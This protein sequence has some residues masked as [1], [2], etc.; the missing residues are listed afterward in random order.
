MAPVVE[1]SVYQSVLGNHDS[2]PIWEWSIIGVNQP[3]SLAVSLNGAASISVDVTARSYR[4]SQHL[5]AGSHT[6]SVTAQFDTLFGLQASGS[7]SAVVA[8]VQSLQA[9]THTDNPDDPQYDYDPSCPGSTP[10][11]LCMHEAQRVWDALAANVVGQLEDVVVAVID[12]GYVVDMS[13]NPHDDLAGNLLTGEGYDFISSPVVAA[14]GNGID[15]DAVDKG[16][17]TKACGGAP[18]VPPSWHGT[19]VG[20][21]IAAETDNASY[22]AGMGWQWVPGV[23]ARLWVMPV[24]VLGCGGGTSYDIAQG[25]RY[26]AGLANDSETLPTTPAKVLN[27]SFGGPDYDSVME[28]AL[29]DAVAAGAILVAATANANS[30]LFWPARSPYTIAVGAVGSNSARASY[31]NHGEGIDVVA[32]GGDAITGGAGVIT[33]TAG[34][35]CPTPCPWSTAAQDG[36]SFA[37]PYV[38]AA[39]ALVA[40]IDPDLTLWQARSL[41]SDSAVDLGTAG[42]DE[43]FGYGNLDAYALLG[44]YPPRPMAAVDPLNQLLTDDVVGTPVTIVPASALSGTLVIEW[45]PEVSDRGGAGARLAGALGAAI[46]GDGPLSLVALANGQDRS[47]VRD[48][49]LAD[50]EVKA[51]HYNLRYTHAA[52]R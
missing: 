15:P 43:D 42:W 24:R 46:V 23:T 29:V 11:A 20:G 21:I 10:W 38:A 26:A 7:A 5:A 28:L 14:D 47:A 33:L 39:L 18:F 45:H 4:P 1:V 13:G 32:A 49:L 36:T 8:T 12:T 9:F 41:L 6:L 52:K 19:A 40:A 30:P 50:G 48:A 25:I 35:D 37:T 44:S 31:S 27:L 51:V 22:V 16:D 17:G 2:R 3:L 34:P